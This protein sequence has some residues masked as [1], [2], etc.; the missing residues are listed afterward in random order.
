[1]ST[2]TI[3]TCSKCGGRVCVPTAYYSVNPP[4]PTCQSCGAT[5]AQPH[6]PVIPMDDYR[7]DFD[8]IHPLDG[9]NFGGDW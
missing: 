2:R 9:D 4:V 8:D 6:G 1:M 7:P 3:G 5:R